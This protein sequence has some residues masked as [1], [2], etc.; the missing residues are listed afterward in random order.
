M[1]KLRILLATSNQGKLRELREMTRSLDVEILSWQDL[2]YHPEIPETGQTFADNAAHKA[3]EAARFSGLPAL[4]DDSGLEVDALD[5]R[6]GVHSARYAGPGASDEERILKLL[7]EL[8]G[9][10]EQERKARFRCVAAFADPKGPLG[11]RV[12]LT[13]G[14]CEG[15]ILT[16]PEGTGGFGYDPVFF[17]PPSGKTFAELA[18]EEK[19]RISHRAR[20]LEAMVRFL[21]RYLETGRDRPGPAEADTLGKKS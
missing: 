3:R 16:H 1:P 7:T 17:H 11:D 4:A 20:A 10:P 13:E 19:N 15:K 14:S 2:P 9:I 18:P 12:H 5:G 21:E 6:P 8:E